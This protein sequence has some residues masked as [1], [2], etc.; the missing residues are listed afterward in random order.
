MIELAFFSPNGYVGEYLFHQM[1]RQKQIAITGITR[2]TD[3]DM[4]EETFDILLY[5]ASITSA[6]KE[7]PLKYITDNCL[8]AVQMVDFCKLHE[9]KRIIYISTDEIY[10]QLNAEKVTESTVMVHPNIYATT[11]YLAERIIIESGIPYYILRLP[12]VVG[13]KWGDNFI[14]SVMEK[15]QRNEDVNIYNGEK[16]FNNLVEISDLT[17]FILKLVCRD[18]YLTSEVF[19][20]GNCESIQ[21]LEMIQ[22]IKEIYHSSSKIHNEENSFRRCFVLNVEKAVSYGY[23]SKKIKSILYDLKGIR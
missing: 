6:R 9:V 4:I 3:I 22:F 8:S 5:T 23:T 16:N 10:G 19:V 18:N 14:Y 1:E 13:E 17:K 12:G 15:M 20:L 21:L 11:K 7:T 2:E